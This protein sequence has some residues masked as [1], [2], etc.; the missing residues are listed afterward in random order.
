MWKGRNALCVFI[1]LFLFVLSLWLLSGKANI[2][3]NTFL[4]LHIKLLFERQKAWITATSLS[5]GLLMAWWAYDFSKRKKKQQ[6][7]SFRTNKMHLFIFCFQLN[8]VLGCE[9]SFCS[10]FFF[11]F[12]F[13]LRFNRIRNY[14]CFWL[15]VMCSKQSVWIGFCCVR[16]K[17]NGNNNLYILMSDLNGHFFPSRYLSHLLHSLN[18][19]YFFVLGRKCLWKEFCIPVAFPFSISSCCFLS[20]SIDEHNMCSMDKWKMTCVYQYIF[21]YIF[22]IFFIT[23]EWAMHQ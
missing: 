17:T 9:S 15:K 16:V 3:R 12:F 5:I 20:Y 13:I 21:L 11:S 2:C 8:I 18:I 7:L 14:L 23:N 19:V 6:N 4:C 22:S 10:D 1:F